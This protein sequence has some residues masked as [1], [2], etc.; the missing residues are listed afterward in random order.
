M[1]EINKITQP[2]TFQKYSAR[3]KDVIPSAISLGIRIS[4]TDD[5][6]LASTSWH[7]MLALPKD[8]IRKVGENDFYFVMHHDRWAVTVAAATCTKIAGDPVS[9]KV[10]IDTKSLGHHVFITDYTKWLAYPIHISPPISKVPI[11]GAMRT[12]CARTGVPL[13]HRSGREGF[14]DVTVPYLTKLMVAEKAFAKDG[15]APRSRTDR[16][17]MLLKAL[18]KDMPPEELAAILLKCAPQSAKKPMCASTDCAKDMLDKADEQEVQKAVATFHDAECSKQIWRE[19][20]KPGTKYMDDVKAVKVGSKKPPSKASAAEVARV[21]KI[22]WSKCNKVEDVRTLLP[23]VPG[24]T[25]QN[26]RW[27]RCWTAYYPDVVPGSRTRTY[28]ALVKEPS[29]RKHVVALAHKMHERKT[30][31]PSPY[32]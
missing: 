10:A 5:P 27:K 9:V 31:K 1:A 22:D 3:S 32:T 4:E 29:V 16:V 18:F 12:L 28:G 6:F 21:K 19:T 15:T 8:I 24:C 23:K 7:S 11:V 14:P 26:V 13:I 25:V 20:M 17:A 30:G 2:N